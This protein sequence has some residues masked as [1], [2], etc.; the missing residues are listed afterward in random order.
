MLFTVLYFYLLAVICASFTFYR[1]SVVQ[2]LK[3]RFLLSPSLIHVLFS[4]F[5]PHLHFILYA[6]PLNFSVVWPCCQ[7]VPSCL[8]FPCWYGVVC[9]PEARL[10]ASVFLDISP[11]DRIRSPPSPIEGICPSPSRPSLQFPN[12]QSE[13]CY[14]AAFMHSSCRRI[15]AA[16]SSVQWQGY[17]LPHLV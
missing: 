15:C 11:I 2:Y 7:R 6:R 10:S 12:S 17:F 14:P 9:C 1:L 3:S 16:P 8:L 5:F 4:W 13:L